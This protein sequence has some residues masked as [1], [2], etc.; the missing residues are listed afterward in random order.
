[1]SESSP[2]RAAAQRSSYAAAFAPVRVRYFVFFCLLPLAAFF[3][4]AAAA[5]PLRVFVSVA[6]EKTFVTRVGGHRVQVAVMV[7]PGSSPHTYEPTPRQIAA[8]VDS[9]L[10]FR[11]GVPFERSWMQRIRSMNPRMKV[12]DLREGLSPRNGTD[13]RHPGTEHGPS[14]QDFHIWTSPRRVIAMAARIRDALTDSDPA[15]ASAYEANYQAFAADLRALDAEI[16]SLLAGSSKRRF[17]VFHPA[18]GYFA[19]EYGLQQIAIEVGGKTPGA[20]ALGRLIERAKREEIH[21]IFVQR[22]Y[23]SASALAVARALDA[24]IIRVDP[25][26]EDYAASLLHLA[27]SLREALR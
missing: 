5:L 26:A 11:I 18:W 6:P 17:L 20:A 13:H 22:Q 1:M 4:T 8:L 2:G 14:L 16:R 7:Q 23:S 19:D 27:R 9:D 10:Y 25:L 24:R 3:T 15:G 21:T 12:I